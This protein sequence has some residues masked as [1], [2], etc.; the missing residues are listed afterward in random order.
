M[1]LLKDQSLALPVGSALLLLWLLY[2][3]VLYFRFHHKYNFPNLVPGVP[4]FGNMLQ[5]PTD[6][7]ERRI[8]LHKL[9]EK[10]GKLYVSTITDKQALTT[11]LIQFHAQGGL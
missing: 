10:Y 4:L 6:T 7:A 11:H 2:R 3:T 8:Y 5:I 9:A 1:K